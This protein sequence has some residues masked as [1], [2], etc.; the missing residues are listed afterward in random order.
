M[1]ADAL[2]Q[3]ELPDIKRL[4]LGH[5]TNYR[6]KGFVVGQGVDAMGAT[7]ELDDAV[8]GG[9]HSGLVATTKYTKYKVAA[10]TSRLNLLYEPVAAC[11]RFR[12][13]RLFRGL[14]CRL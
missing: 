10:A 13:F 1:S 12:V 7:G 4:G 11:L 9:R 8:S 14:K 6:M 3:A 2:G 5:G